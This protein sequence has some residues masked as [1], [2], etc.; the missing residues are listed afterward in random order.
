[1]LLKNF[2]SMAIYQ[3]V[4]DSTEYKVKD[5]FPLKPLA[6]KGER[7]APAHKCFHHLRFSANTVDA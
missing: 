1:M 3:V 6:Y 7:R 2:T 4:S 5:K